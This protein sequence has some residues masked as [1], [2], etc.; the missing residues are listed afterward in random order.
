MEDMYERAEFAKELGSVHR[1]DR[2]RDRLHGDPV[3]GE[4]GAQERHD[5]ASA[6]RRATRLT[7]RQKNHGMNF[8]RHLQVDAHGR[9]RPHPR[10]HGGRQARRRSADDQG[11][12]RHAARSRKTPQSLEHGL[13]FEQ[14]WA[15]LTR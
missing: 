13:F 6:P 1:H 15:S 11:L 7:T 3:D 12:L 10:G 2:S 4:V 9:R 8:P 14:D 5:P